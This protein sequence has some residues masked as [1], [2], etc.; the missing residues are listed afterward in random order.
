MPLKRTLL[1]YSVKGGRMLLWPL[2]RVG[3]LANAIN[4]DLRRLQFQLTCPVNADD[5]F[6]VTYPKSG[7]TWMQMILYQLTT[8]GNMNFKH[9]S[10]KS[11]TWEELMSMNTPSLFITP[12]IFKSHLPYGNI[13]KSPCKYI[14][15]V[16]DYRDVAVSFYH[17]YWDYKFYRKDFDHFFHRKFIKN[18]EYI[19]WFKHVHEWY[20]NPRK[21]DVLYIR[22]EDMKT[23]LPGVVRRVVDFCGFEVDEEQ[24]QRVVQRSDFSFM[25]QH[26]EKFDLSTEMLLRMGIN[27]GAFIRKGKVGG[28]K[29]YFKPSHLDVCSKL[30]R[31]WITG[32]VDLP[33]DL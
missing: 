16:R 26:E 21:L 22:Y 18:S 14:Y 24:F 7:T 10:Q 19:H 29:D 33:Y 4:D 6:V 8:N 9:I 25:K 13:P 23:D 20:T 27:S 3:N 32:K 31:R 15:I 17:H 30:Y 12:R 1:T 2:S 5:I 28:W 11:P